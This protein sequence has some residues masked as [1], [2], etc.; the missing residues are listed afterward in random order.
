MNNGI[1]IQI[2]NAGS[3]I[4]SSSKALDVTSSNFVQ[5]REQ[6]TDIYNQRSDLLKQL[7]SAKIALTFFTLANFLSYVLIF[8]FFYKKIKELKDGKQSIK[9]KLE[10]QLSETY[11][12]LTF[13]DK[14]QLEKSW[15]N[16]IDT[17]NEL[18]NSE[19]I[20]DLTYTEVVD[21]VKARSIAKNAITKTEIKKI[22]REI[23]FI[24]S[25]LPYALL[26]NANGPDLFFFPTFL[27]LYKDNE[28][29]G[30]FDLREI[31]IKMELIGYIEEEKVPGDT[32]IVDHTWKKANKHGSADKRFKD[33]YQIP[34]VKYGQMVIASDTGL[35]E[36]FMFS[37]FD[38][39]SEFTKTYVHHSSLL[40]IPTSGDVSTASSPKEPP[41]K[42]DKDIINKLIKVSSFGMGKEEDYNKANMLKVIEEAENFSKDSKNPKLFYWLGIAWRN[43]T[44][45][46]IRGDERKEYLS[47]AVDNYQ[48]ALDLAKDNLPIQ[49]PIEKRHNTEFLDQ[50]D[51]AGDLGHLLVDEAI[52]RDLDRA[53]P[54]LKFV[55][56]ATG[57]YEPCL[58]SFAELYYKRGD[59]DKCLEIGLN[60]HNR[61]LTSQEWKDSPP[62]A[63]LGIIGSAYRALA[64]QA[65]KENNTEEAINY[66]EHMEELGVATE[67]DL[68]I[69]NNLRDTAKY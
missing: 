20:W 11:I 48:K 40:G 17:F 13:A 14:S 30:I 18:M 60:I 6:I 50:I 5:L 34:I 59:Y 68:K 52:I 31:D 55:Y 45:W 56:E 8:G 62:P 36:A 3:I 1:D 65:K 26:P 15:L 32:E 44:G 37:N 69:L 27:L 54:I 22:Q 38:A 42:S 61:T 24:K 49:L 63:P 46:H 66:F 19:K 39:F 23:E 12:S 21:N 10:K 25:D 28:K 43:F 57:E 16:C 67:N 47:K 4:R 2:N 64:K 58:Y 9:E 7:K 33:N 29:F 35:E 53:E 41:T 51:I